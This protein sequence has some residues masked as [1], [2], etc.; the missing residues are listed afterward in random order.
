MAIGGVRKLVGQAMVNTD[1]SF[2]SLHAL[3]FTH[4]GGPRKLIF[5]KPA[6]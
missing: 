3:L 6:F 2:F 5:G 1:R 4:F